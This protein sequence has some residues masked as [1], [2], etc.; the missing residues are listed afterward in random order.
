LVENLKRRG[1]GEG[2]VIGGLAPL[3]LG[4]KNATRRTRVVDR[5]R[6]ADDGDVVRGS[7]W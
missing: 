5:V 1:R 4:A 2:S 7:R 6:G 3:R